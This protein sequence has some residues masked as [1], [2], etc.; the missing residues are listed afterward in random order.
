MTIRHTATIVALAAGV[1][2]GCAESNALTQI[3]P[4]DDTTQTPTDDPTAGAD[5]GGVYAYFH[6]NVEVGIDGATVVIRSDGVP[7]HGSPY[8][9]AGDSRYE[10][11][12]GTNGSFQLNPNR[13]AEQQLTFRIPVAPSPAGFNAATP[14]G[15]IGVSVNGVPIFNQYAG[16]DRPLTFEIDSFD[17]YNGHPQQTGQYHYHVEP[18]AL[19]TELGEDALIGVLL[20]GYPV[21]GPLENG[22]Y[23]TNA[24]LDAL[25]GHVG[26]TPEFPEGIYHYHITSEDPYI[27]GAGFYGTAGT[28][29]Q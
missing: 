15:P 13:I 21:Y 3:D 5:L 19:T 8:F 6:S 28:V 9:N 11:Y 7:T 17:Q 27:N 16:P 14:L 20:D 2:I 23:V 22:S 26:A 25:H 29:S 4:G 24:D 18:V 12:N 10:A 1:L